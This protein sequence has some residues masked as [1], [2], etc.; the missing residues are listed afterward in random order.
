[1]NES[2]PEG[3]RG[4]EADFWPMDRRKAAAEAMGICGSVGFEVV[5]DNEVTIELM[6]KSGRESYGRRE[7]RR[8]RSL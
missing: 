2:N 8:L 6:V 5:A 1:M 3:R 4:A 7:Q